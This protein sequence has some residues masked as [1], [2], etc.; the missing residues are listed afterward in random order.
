MTTTRQIPHERQHELIEQTLHEIR[1]DVKW[2]LE[3]LGHEDDGT[4]RLTRMEAILATI[5]TRTDA[6]DT[7][8]NQLL[9]RVDS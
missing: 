1:G 8:L 9:E 2:L 5:A 3:E 4:G 6:L 7:K